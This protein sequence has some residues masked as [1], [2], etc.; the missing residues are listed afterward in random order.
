MPL[1]QQAGLGDTPWKR[2]WTRNRGG[3][4]HSARTG[5]FCNGRI[6][7]VKGAEGQDFLDLVLEGKSVMTTV[8]H[9][10]IVKDVA[11][12]EKDSLSSSY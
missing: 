10:D 7:L 2:L 4:W 8:G 12:V 6:S 11:L 9:T 3:V 5:S 1:L